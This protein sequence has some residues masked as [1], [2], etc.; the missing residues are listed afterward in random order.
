MTTSTAIY[1]P[2]ETDIT[3]IERMADHVIAALIYLGLDEGIACA[4]PETWA[5]ALQLMESDDPAIRRIGYVLG[6]TALRTSPATMLGL[7][8][9]LCNVLRLQVPTTVQ[10]I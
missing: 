8:N 10:T 5:S 3:E 9:G 2:A 6:L 1:I 7:V 4:F